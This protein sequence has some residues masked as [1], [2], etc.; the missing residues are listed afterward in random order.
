M[1]AD[2]DNTS[3]GD[4]HSG[5]ADGHEAATLLQQNGHCE[6]VGKQ[7]GS[8]AGLRA[9]LESSDHQAVDG[10]A[11]YAVCTLCSSGTRRPPLQP[12]LVSLLLRAVRR[13]NPLP[14]ARSFRP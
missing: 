13:M 7:K 9:W 5:Y 12:L 14:K 2:M 11:L 6:E 4:D 8:F 10:I 3:N 1:G